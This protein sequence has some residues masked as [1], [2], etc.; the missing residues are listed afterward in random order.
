V[1]RK[2]KSPTPLSEYNRFSKTIG[3]GP[4]W[5][6]PLVYPEEGKKRVTVD[7]K[8]LERLDE[9]EFINDNLLEFYMRWLQEEQKVPTCTVYFF[10]TH[11]YTNL[12]NPATLPRGSKSTINFSAVERWTAK[13]DIFSHDFVVVPVNELHHWY[14]AIICNLPNVKRT[15][16]AKE[17]GGASEDAPKDPHQAQGTINEPVEIS[18]YAE[19]QPSAQQQAADEENQET[20]PT[21]TLTKKTD[22]LKL[23]SSPHL[24]V[25]DTDD[26]AQAQ[27]A[28]EEEDAEKDVK[29]AEAA[30][31][32]QA[33]KHAADPHATEAVQ[34]SNSQ[35]STGVFSN[36][37]PTRTE[38]KKKGRRKS[39]PPP[40]KYDTEQ[41]MIVILDSMGG[42]HGRT[43]SNLKDYLVEEART[44]RGMEI[45]KNTFKGHHARAGIP[46]QQNYYDCGIYVCGYLHKFMEDPKEF[47]QKL[48]TQTFNCE[49]DWPLMDPE[50]MRDNMRT[51]LQRMAAEQQKLGLAKKAQKKA[52]K[53]V[54]AVFNAPKATAPVNNKIVDLSSPMK[55]SEAKQN[56][57]RDVQHV[58]QTDGATSE[59]VRLQSKH[60][61]PAKV[62]LAAKEQDEEEMLF[63]SQ[64][65]H[66]SNPPNKPD[67]LGSIGET[68]NKEH[69][70]P[71]DDEDSQQQDC[72]VPDSQSQHA[73]DAVNNFNIYDDSSAI[74]G[75]GAAPM[76]DQPAEEEEEE[77][78]GVSSPAEAS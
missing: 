19:G 1:T 5:G 12:A 71:Y 29:L 18:E 72:Y 15:L 74:Q 13:D 26:Q 77:F 66:Q 58:W 6:Q 31:E 56:P 21:R 47:G 65:E 73:R 52:K 61:S 69:T 22:G 4:S 76:D 24:L 33:Q 78:N 68:L 55:P 44:K 36:A 8:D 11:F 34:T 49:V 16:E 2:L 35:A 20:T 64:K 70:T 40:R 60:L 59:T 63:P 48:M 7:F 45:D 39:G 57:A 53:Q 50:K 30:G 10:N 23:A 51:M 37:T 3:L 17:E 41:P 67:L 32:N 62:R 27:N 54:A 75:T 46:Q 43:I 9:G 28:A 14:V 38:N 25:D 42:S